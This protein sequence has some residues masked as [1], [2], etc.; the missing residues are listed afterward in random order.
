MTD[1]NDRA[2]PF[3][4]V[5]PEKAWGLTKREYFA[6][7][8]MQGL[9]S[10]QEYHKWIRT[11]Y[12]TEAVACADALIAELNKENGS[13]T[14]DTVSDSSANQKA[15]QVAVEALGK[16]INREIKWE[17][18]LTMELQGHARKALERIRE[19]QEGR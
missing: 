8:A 14:G 16:I 6:A 17:N 3:D 12:A 9:L 18:T 1:P 7:M 2:F 4:Y 19:I 13:P 10:E 5:Q 11:E 15:L